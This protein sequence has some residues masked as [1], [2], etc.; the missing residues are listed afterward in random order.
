MGIG[1]ELLRAAFAGEDS[2]EGR[3]GRMMVCEWGIALVALSRNFT[4]F[5]KGIS[6]P[7]G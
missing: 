2:D 4:A 5:L 1:E 3:A 7:N 6:S